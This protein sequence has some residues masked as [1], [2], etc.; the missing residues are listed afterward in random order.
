MTDADWIK[1][2]RDH[3]YAMFRER[4]RRDGSIREHRTRGITA[5]TCG[6]GIVL[7]V[8]ILSALIYFWNVGSSERKHEIEVACITSGGTWTAIGG[9]ASKVCVHL[10]KATAP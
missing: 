7:V 2:E 8:G 1:Q 9:G 4:E 10:D 5:V 3:E 6:V